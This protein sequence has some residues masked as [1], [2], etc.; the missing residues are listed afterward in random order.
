MEPR[1]VLAVSKSSSSSRS[2]P[3]TTRPALEGGVKVSVEPEERCIALTE[4]AHVDDDLAHVSI[5]G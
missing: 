1:P 3:N 4:R 2:L 5:R